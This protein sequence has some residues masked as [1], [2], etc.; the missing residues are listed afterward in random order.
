MIDKTA[1]PELV[2]SEVLKKAHWLFAQ[3]CDFVAG[4]MNPHQIPE[5]SLPEFAFVGR[6]NV[7]KSSLINALTNRKAL[8]RVSHTPGRTQQ[9]NFFKLRDVLHIVD[10]PGY[11]YA[12]VSRKMVQN[13]TSMI[14]DYLKGRV[15]LK[16]VF[17]LIDS[18]H[19]LKESDKEVMKILDESAITYQIILTKG[20]KLEPEDRIKIKNKVEEDIKSFPAAFPEIILSS[21]EDKTGIDEIKITI[22]NLL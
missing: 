13:W 14:F 21:S 8:A 18:R 7:G 12:K 16:R 3:E 10:M 15:E 22:L 1:N 20:D 17:L 11:G 4:A 9:M 19:G 5:L 6:S 2:D